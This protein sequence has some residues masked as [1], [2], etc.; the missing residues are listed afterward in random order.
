MRRF[1]IGTAGH[2]DH[3][4]TALVRALTG[5]DTDRLPEEKRRGISIDLGFAPLALAPDLVAGIVDVPGHER[6][7]HNMLA[8]AAGVDVALLV[9]AADEGVM[10]QT[11][12]HL[13]ILD[14]LGISTGVVAIT[15]C[16]LVEQDWLALVQEEVRQNL[17]GTCLAGAPVLA[18][19]AV[20]GQGL[21]E[22]RQ[23]LVELVQD[24]P[25][26]A[27]TG[28]VRLPVDRVFS[29][30][31]FGTVVTGTLQGNGVQAGDHLEILP[32][33]SI[34]RV[35]GV[36]IHG[37]PVTKAPARCRVALNLVER[38][39]L[40]RGNVLVTPG[41]FRPQDTLVVKLRL[42]PGC[43]LREGARVRFHAG[44][45]A[46]LA[47]V[48]LLNGGRELVAGGEEVVALRCEQPVVVCWGDPF[49]LRS[50]SPAI[51]I[52]GGR[53]LDGGERY[54]WRKRANL[55]GLQALA[56]ATESE[57]LLALLGHVEPQPPAIAEL[58]GR[59][60][61]GC[62]QVRER[63][64]VFVARGEAFVLAGGHALAKTGLERMSRQVVPML[65][66]PCQIPAQKRFAAGRTA[67][68]AL[69]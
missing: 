36:Q 4:K 27:E 6:F 66:V 1:V 61:W 59:L 47:R 65:P 42:L 7:V 13:A 63:L 51:T 26:V 24:L 32:G 2:I 28:A 22:L 35:R 10:P 16:D 62:Q 3:G 52:G 40:E 20:T 68:G 44:A 15:K 37:Q 64:Q 12:E 49:I 33:G 29:V 31:G 41:L 25:P 45:V 38:E 43:S 60:G 53:L 11:R 39:K 56:Q 48:H 58:A 34:V 50:Y 14:L 57:S 54:R 21:S 8:G 55:K 23:T 30:P 69:P 67:A 5:H 9:V 46:V 18:V 17:G 19:S